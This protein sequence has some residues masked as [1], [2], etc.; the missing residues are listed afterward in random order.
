MARNVVRIEYDIDG[1]LEEAFVAVPAEELTP[2]GPEY[3][4]TVVGKPVPRVDA[5]DVVT[6]KAKYTYDISLP[7]MLH[8]R[9]L[10]CPHASARVANVDIEEAR[11]LPGVQA[12]L[13]PETSAPAT[14]NPLTRNVRYAGQMVAAVA[15]ESD[16]VAEDAIHL[17]QVEYDV[18]DFVVDRESASEEGA[19]TVG[20]GP[21]RGRP[22]VYD[23]GD[24][25][26]GK[27]EADALVELV[28]RTPCAIHTCLEVHGSVARWEDDQLTVWD[29][30]Q[31]VYRLR[32]PLADFF[33]IPESNVRVIMHHMGGGF[34]SKLGLHN[35]TRVCA[36]L[37]RMA[38]RPVKLMLER[39][40]DFVSTGNRPDSYQIVRAGATKDGTLTVLEM[41]AEGAVGVGG[42]FGP[43][44]LLRELYRCPNVRTVESAVQI[45]AGRAAPFRAPGHPEGAYGLESALD[46]LAE[47]IG[48]DPLEFRRKNFTDRDQVRELPYTSNHLLEA[49][50][51]GSKEIGWD[52]RKAKPGSDPGPRKRG[53]G[54]ACQLWHS[55]GGGPTEVLVR[56]LDDGSAEVFTGTQDLG[57]GTKTA[58]SIVA[59][60]ELG[61]PVE[62]VRTTLADTGLC[63]LGSP[64]GGS[65]TIPSAMPAVRA[66]A[67]DA[68]ERLLVMVREMGKEAEEVTLRDKDV[69]LRPSGERVPIAKLSE[70]WG[71]PEG[72]GARGPNPR[73][74]SI[75]T[76]GVQFAEV[77]VDTETGQVKV[78][79]VAAAHDAGRVINR[80]TW[81]NQV[82]GGLTQGLSFALLEE[83]VMDR[84]TGRMVGANLH[85]YR[86]PTISEIPEIVPIVLDHADP[87]ANSV[88][89]RGL[90]EPPHIPTA[91]A[92]ANA[93][94]NAT[95][96]RMT[97]LPMTPERVLRALEEK[98]KEE[99]R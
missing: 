74:Y 83:R 5:L 11:K 13:T 31:A 14:Q 76:H 37:A 70:R 20:R 35:H 96:A 12:I 50:D 68:K 30:T 52:R 43:G 3:K 25:E 7:G 22:R 34:G 95:G 64:S 77:E 61:I 33:G 29:S 48:I 85:D 94:H 28:L 59:A 60:E 69:I 81:E 17:I 21:N 93:V 46:A 49:Y 97:E 99:S 45:H 16:P 62:K 47:E 65:I 66:A 39:S 32:K 41:E 92:I 51:L 6:G 87:L 40:A 54:M 38:K 80:L 56:I 91:A 58:V 27:K 18:R 63:P 73:E 98:R 36:L 44:R 23:R 67:A 71:T 57:T 26:K 55:G 2:W 84:E 9:V 42:G 90:G 53:I 79:K 1:I 4:A 10:R 8:A 24:V 82:E 15:A 72:N 88:G 89:A 75:N 19:P 78:I 86:I